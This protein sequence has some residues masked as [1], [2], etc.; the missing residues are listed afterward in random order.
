MDLGVSNCPIWRMSY[1]SAENI[2]RKNSSKCMRRIDG[3]HRS[4]SARPDTLYIFWKNDILYR[5]RVDGTSIRSKVT[6]GRNK[7]W[8]IHDRVTLDKTLK[9]KRGF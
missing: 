2:C 7:E 8:E 9:L 5:M 6:T 3:K 4:S 1:E